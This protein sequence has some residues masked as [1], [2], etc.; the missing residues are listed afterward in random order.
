MRKTITPSLTVPDYYQINAQYPLAKKTLYVLLAIDLF[1]VLLH[2]YT[3]SLPAI[4][5]SVKN[6]RLDMDFGFAEI[7]QYV[8]FISSAA[9]LVFLFTKDKTPIY[10]IWAL[11]FLILF[12]DDAFAFH[13]VYG[14]KFVRFFDVPGMF[15]LRA[16]DIGELAM[17]GLIGLFLASTIFYTLLW[18]Q[19]KAKQVTVHFILL[20]GILVFFGVGVDMLHSFLNHL[21]GAGVLTMIEDG[22]E[23][24]AASLILWYSFYLNLKQG[25]KTD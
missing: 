4:E 6:L 18:G 3:F 7:F 23:M 21:P 8:K 11:F 15:G 2:I 20:V 25:A 1:F 22:G 19:K 13:E 24:V 9:L 12:A 14:A 5:G 17:A 16:Q 10:L